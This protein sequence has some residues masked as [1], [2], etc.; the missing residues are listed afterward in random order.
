MTETMANDV[1]SKALLQTTIADLESQL[2]GFKKE[3]LSLDITRGKPATAQLDLSSSIDGILA[4][5]YLENSSGEANASRSGNLD[6]RN[7]GGLEGIQSARELFA[8]IL[9]TNIDETLVFGNASLNLMFQSVLSCYYFGVSGP[10][11]AWST[12]GKI[13]FLC[14]VPGYDRHFSICER[15]GIEMINVPMVDTGPDMDF[16]EQQLANDPLIKGIWCVPRFSNPTGHVYSDDTVKRFAKLANI[17]GK[18]F[19]IFWD[20]AY[21][22]H[23]LSDNAAELLCLMTQ[24]KEQGT[25]D[26]ALIFGSTSKVTLAGAGVSFVGCSTRNMNMLKRDMIVSSIGPDKINQL[27]HVRFLQNQT[28]IKRLMAKHADIL[29]P[30]FALVLEKLSNT[31]TNENCGR[32]TNPQGGYFVSFDTKPGLA[33]EIVGLAASAGVKL[34]AA[35]A[36]FPYG[37][38]PNDCNIRIAPSFPP[39]EE[40]DK[41]MDVFICCVKLAT[42]KQELELLS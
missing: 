40:L 27:R 16:V 30:K 33:G 42:R 18:H 32:W 3:A 10:D 12:E 5:N 23:A 24:C 15:F 34:T 21:A 28:G 9:G 17:A 22:V 36:T 1:A 4:G 37:K 35:G 2:K 20:N 31:L 38:D 39:L 19:R 7:Y 6:V 11:S 14:P 26:S 29:A 41:A 8:P 25:E 13:K